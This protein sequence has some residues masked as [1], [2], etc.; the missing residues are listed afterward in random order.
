MGQKVDIKQF[1]L[2]VVKV[3]A[4]YVST[5]VLGLIWPTRVNNESNVP[6]IGC[7]GEKKGP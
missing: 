6:R 4:M 7:S 2:F 3:L 5:G 1:F